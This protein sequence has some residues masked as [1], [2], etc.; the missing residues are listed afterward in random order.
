MRILLVSPNTERVNMVA[1]PMGLGLV[2]GAARRAGHEVTVLDLLDEPDPREAL[3]RAVRSVDPRVIGFSIRNIDDQERERPRFLLAQVLPIVQACRACSSAPI[4][5]GGAGYSIFPDAV[6]A[7]LGADFGVSGDGEAAF[8]ALLDCLDAGRDPQSIPG[9]LAAAGKRSAPALAPSFDRELDDFPEWDTAL[10]APASGDQWV[11]IQTR[12]G[13][14]NDC[15]Y[16][17]T[18][19]IQ[20]RTIRARSPRTVVGLVARL[21]SGGCARFYF[22]DNSF[23]IPESY[24]L[25]LCGGIAELA[26]DISWRCIIYPHRLSRA[27][28][29]AMARSGCVEAAVG[30]ES[31]SAEVLRAMNKRFTPEDVRATCNLLGAHGIRR[32]GFLL[33]GGPGETRETVEKSLAFADSLGLEAIKTTIG[34]RVYPGT[35]LARQAVSE[36]I[37]AAADDLLLPRFYVA[38][39]LEPWI[40]ERVRLHERRDA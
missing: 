21:A 16:C 31:G 11:P 6:L 3:R 27:L 9:V 18:A 33:L 8:V 38:P 29:E 39:G 17:S 40:H 12:R 26:R 25:E 2:A 28:V 13:C 14:P 15:S 24:A 32:M 34:I 30:F 37:I 23:N 5:V 1:L 7:Y 4:V 20:G 10:T 36:G 22:V 19:A 35:A